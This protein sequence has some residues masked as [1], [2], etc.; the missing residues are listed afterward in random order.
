MIKGQVADDLAAD[1]DGLNGQI[2]AALRQKIGAG[3]VIRAGCCDGQA[4]VLRLD[5]GRIPEF[6]IAG[7]PVIGW[8]EPVQ[9][10]GL[11]RRITGNRRKMPVGQVGK[12]PALKQVA[13][14]HHQRRG[15]TAVAMGDHLGQGRL[16]QA[17][18][19][20]RAA[21]IAVADVD[22][23]R[24]RVTAISL[25]EQLGAVEDVVEGGKDEHVLAKARGFPDRA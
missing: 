21:G 25:P 23:Q 20:M 4:D 14:G 22:D 1:K 3:G 6:Q 5:V 10:G 19:V 24:Q 2:G 7:G 11:V 15:G 17:G 13:G 16:D 18:T 8:G 12:E 9:G